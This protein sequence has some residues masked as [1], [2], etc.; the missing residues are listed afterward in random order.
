M[1]DYDD[2]D[3]W[4]EGGFSRIQE[5]IA[6]EVSIHFRVYG[7]GLEYWQVHVANVPRNEQWPN[8]VIRIITYPDNGRVVMIRDMEIVEEERR[9]ICTNPQLGKRVLL[10]RVRALLPVGLPEPNTY[11]EGGMI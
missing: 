3:L 2:D 5:F 1:R 9:L 10:P 7:T 4:D 11:T 8:Q 6:G